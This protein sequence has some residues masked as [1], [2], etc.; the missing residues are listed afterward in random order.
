MKT[1]FTIIS[2]I[3]VLCAATLH[4]ATINVP[5]DQPTIQAGIDASVNGDTVL[6]APGTYYERV[7]LSGKAIVLTSEAG[8]DSTTIDGYRG[9]LS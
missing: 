3:A 2:C 5:V 8:P 4:A 1:S 7:N 6:V 9:G